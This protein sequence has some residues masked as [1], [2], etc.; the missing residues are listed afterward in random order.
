MRII[1]VMRCVITSNA[2]F[3]DQAADGARFRDFLGKWLVDG[4]MSGLSTVQWMK[5]RKHS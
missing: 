4:S 2:I 3:R 1:Y 5:N